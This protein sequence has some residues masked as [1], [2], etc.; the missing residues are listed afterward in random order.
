MQMMVMVTMAMAVMMV[1]VMMN[2]LHELVH[3]ARAVYLHGEDTVRS[4][5]VLVERMRRGVPKA[6]RLMQSI[7]RLV[8]GSH[9]PLSR[10]A[11]PVAARVDVGARR[12]QLERERRT[13]LRI[14]EVG[15]E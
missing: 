15:L 11:Y 6:G 9:R 3:L 12:L 4:R 8:N 13:E 5:R 10:A 2:H 14:S 1:V 7:H